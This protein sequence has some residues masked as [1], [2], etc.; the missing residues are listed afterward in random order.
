MILDEEFY[1]EDVY[2][3]VRA[4]ITSCTINVNRV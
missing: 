3:L 4:R 2:F 1:F